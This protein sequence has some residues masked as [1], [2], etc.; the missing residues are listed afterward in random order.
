MFNSDRLNASITEKEPKRKILLNKGGERNKGH[1]YKLC[2][3]HFE[4][5]VIKR[6]KTMEVGNNNHQEEVHHRVGKDEP[7][8]NWEDVCHREGRSTRARRGA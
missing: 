5:K 1:I 3:V 7:H 8:R 4:E 2:A 6:A